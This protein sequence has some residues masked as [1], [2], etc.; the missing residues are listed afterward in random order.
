M[1][2]VLSISSHTGAQP[3]MALVDVPV[4]C[5]PNDGCVFQLH[6]SCRLPDRE[7]DAYVDCEFHRHSA[8][9]VLHAA[10]DDSVAQCHRG[11]DRGPLRDSGARQQS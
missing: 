7:H 8:H 2:E 5:G 10:S 4:P 1:F 11:M 6:P 9:R 3:S